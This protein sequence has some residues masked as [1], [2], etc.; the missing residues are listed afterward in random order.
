MAFT[1]N[2]FA[3]RLKKRTKELE[4]IKIT[5]QGKIKLRTEKLELL[6]E[7]LE[8]KVK[9]RT[10][11]LETRVN[12]LERFYKLT[13]GRETKMMEL[14]EEI[15]KL[16]N[17]NNSQGNKCIFKGSPYHEFIFNW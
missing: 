17:K 12:E 6:T 14:K 1:I 16:K 2:T 8:E 4:E 7:N 11:E 10:K 13:I 15:K 9:K 5:L 3:N